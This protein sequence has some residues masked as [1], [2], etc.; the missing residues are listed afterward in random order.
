M[1][2]KDRYFDIDLLKTVSIIGV[3]IIHTCTY[4]FDLL[5]FHWLSS[6]FWGSLARAS[7]PIFFMCSGALFLAPDRPFSVKKLFAKSIPRILAAMVFWAVAYKVFHLLDGGALT[8]SGLIQGCKEILVFN[9]EFH[10]YYLQIILLVYL[11]LP[12]TRLVAEH[13]TRRQLEYLLL[14]WV[15][16]GIVYPTVRGF[17]PFTLLTGVARE[18]MLNMTYAA[19]GYGVLGHYLRRY[20]ARWR[21]TGLAEALAGFALTFGGTIA[22]SARDEAFNTLPLEGMTVGVALLAA[23]LFRICAAARPPKSERVRRSVAFV[24]KAS[25]C[26]YLCHVFFNYLLPKLGFSVALFPPVVGIPLVACVTFAASLAVYL[27]LS[28]IPVVKKWLI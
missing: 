24:S 2:E 27:V 22:L 14:L 18:Y 8:L 16:L 9:Q 12:I 21:W 17:W 11:F 25:F 1:R 19:I 7:V 28:K 23:G 26:V 3:I 5:S 4:N 6:V 15:L 20:P 13:A 10:L